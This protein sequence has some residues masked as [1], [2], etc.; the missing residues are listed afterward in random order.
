MYLKIITL[1]VNGIAEKPKRTNIFNYMRTLNADLYT[2]QETHNASDIDELNW[3]REWGGPVFWSRGT[4]HSRG[5]AIFVHPRLSH[6]I[7][8]V[9]RDNDGRVVAIKLDVD[10]TELNLLT[11]YAPTLSGERKNFFND[12]WRYQT[13]DSNLIITGDFN[14]VPNPDL[15]KCGGNPNTGNIGMLELTQFTDT[16]QL[17]DIW[18]V[19]HPNDKIYTWHNKDFSIRCRLDRVYVTSPLVTS[20]RAH[21]RACPLSDHSVAEISVKLSSSRRRGPGTWKLN[22]SLF[23]DDYYCRETEAFLKYWSLRKNAFANLQEW[24]DECKTKLKS[25]AIKHSVRRS[26]Q[27][28][29]KERNLLHELSR[30]HNDQTP[31]VHEIQRIEHEL[32]SLADEKARGAQIRSRASWIEEGERPTRYFFNLEKRKQPKSCISKLKTENDTE[33]NNNHAILEYTRA[34]YQ[35]LYDN[36]Q[37]NSDTQEWFLNK[38]NR[39]LN[40]NERTRAE[41]PV[42]SDE[43]E[44]AIKK[45]K[46][47]KSPGPDGLPSEFYKRFWHLI[48]VNLLELYNYNFDSGAMSESQTNALLRLLYKKGEKA[49]LKNWRPISLLNTD[50]KLLSTVLAQRLKPL[51]PVIIHED[52]TCGVPGRSI[53]ENL[54]RLRDAAYDAI[55]SNSNT[56]MINLDQEKA[57]D[58][59][60]RNFLFKTMSRMNFGPSFIHWIKTLYEHANSNIVNNGWISEPVTLHRGVRQ[61]CPLSPLLYIIVAETLANAIRQDQKIVGIQIPGSPNP[62]KITQ[63]ADDGTLT[64]RDDLSVIRSFEVIQQYERATG[65]KLN[66]EKTEGIYIGQQAGRTTG[67]VNIS[68]KTDAIHVLGTHI[69][70]DLRQNWTNAVEK[71]EKYFERWSTRTL[72]ITGKALLIKTYAISSIMYLASVFVIPTP[73]VTRIHSAMY[74][75]LWNNKNELI[76]RETCNLPSARGGLAIPDLHYVNRSSKTK[77]IASITD[78]TNTAQWTCY[79]R[80]WLGTILSTI[81]PDWIWL[82]D[83]RKPHADPSRIPPWYDVI[84]DTTQ[85]F[86]NELVNCNNITNKTIYGWL[87]TDIPCP[88]AERAWKRVI[89]PSPDFNSTWNNIVNSLSNN[90]AKEVVWKATHRVLTTR[91][92]IASWGMAVPTRCPFCTKTEDAEHVLVGCHRARRLWNEVQHLLDRIN[93]SHYEISMGSLLFPKISK[94]QPSSFVIQYLLHLR[95]L[96][97]WSTRNLQILDNRRRN[98]D[99]QLLFKKELKN[100]IE[101][102]KRFHRSNILTYWTHKNV[103]CSFESDTLTFNFN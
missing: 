60:D 65:S 31:D 56:T 97:L 81:R 48:K 6:D 80:Y 62:S 94:T 90:R 43:L 35:R 38:I 19:Q 23:S 3:A 102:D 79:A 54:F 85:H 18:R 88:K 53:F 71:T 73:I 99:P 68:W 101:H 67:P 42:T 34:F 33:I 11:V 30:L 36:E 61:G 24:W 46:L 64:V 41:G 40:P 17:T 10:G 95:I 76:A 16:N 26:K 75:F 83:L 58:K 4:R 86:R 82:R 72:S 14:C 15:D 70:N 27:Y 57:F 77:F 44:A 89:N 69:G 52:Q 49:Q 100:K 66:M 78:R 74:K 2:L 51:L 29:A 12:L 37:T 91:A 93:G 50:Y 96:T 9:S 98:V 92:Y 5:V 22:I 20:T 47:N 45:L 84:K 63:Y 55:T 25:I 7:L 1:N 13:G 87:L 21:I 28:K 103:L 59:I 8:Q 32:T 39:K